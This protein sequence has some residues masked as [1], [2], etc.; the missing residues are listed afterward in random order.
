LNTGKNKTISRIRARRYHQ[1]IQLG[2]QHCS[3]IIIGA[4]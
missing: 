2:A 4:K 3:A 1:A